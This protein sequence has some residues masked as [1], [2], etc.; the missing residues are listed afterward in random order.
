MSPNNVSLQMFPC[1]QLTQK[2]K[3][4]NAG[5]YVKSCWYEMVRPGSTFNSTAEQE[6]GMFIRISK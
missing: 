1:E 4:I 3:A 6:H 5:L 2:V